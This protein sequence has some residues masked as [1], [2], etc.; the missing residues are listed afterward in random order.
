MI[1]GTPEP[2][3]IWEVRFSP[4]NRYII[5][6]VRQKGPY[7]SFDLVP[8]TGLKAKRK[9][10]HDHQV[11]L[12]AHYMDVDFVEPTD[13]ELALFMQAKLTPEVFE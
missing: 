12:G 7:H 5:V 3:K 10:I 8:M 4:N 2:G 6:D 9:I 13:E 11:Q 1:T